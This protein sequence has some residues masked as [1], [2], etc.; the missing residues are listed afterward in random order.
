MQDYRLHVAVM[1]CATYRLT[2]T[3]IDSFWPFKPIP[4]L[5]EITVA[6]DV[7]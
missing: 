4:Q 7:I 3:K 5:A 1:I 2:D 6:C